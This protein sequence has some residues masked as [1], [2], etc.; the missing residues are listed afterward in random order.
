MV[1]SEAPPVRWPLPS[2]TTAAAAPL[3]VKQNDF[4]A[5]IDHNR[6][7]GAEALICRQE[8]GLRQDPKLLR[9]RA[10]QIV[11]ASLP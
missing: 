5:G 8:V 7:K 4:C 10:G 9:R 11:D 1:G 3:G 2:S 6:C